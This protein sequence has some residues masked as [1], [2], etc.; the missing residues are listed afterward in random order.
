MAKEGNYHIY[1]HNDKGSNP[2]KPTT[3]RKVNSPAKSGKTT[4]KPIRIDDEG[5]KSVPSAVPFSSAINTAI[6]LGS[7]YGTA[8]AVVG[9]ALAVAEVVKTANETTV[10]LNN[11]VANQTGDYTQSMAWSN[12]ANQQHNLFH[13]ISS[14]WNAILKE[15]EWAKANERTEQTR[16]LLGDSAINTLTKGV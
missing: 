16:T 15:Q 12:Y 6:K 3:P 4:A 1:I 14:T 10:K 7:K 9:V 11:Y 13:P 5:T 8:G 2:S